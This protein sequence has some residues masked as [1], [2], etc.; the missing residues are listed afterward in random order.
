MMTDLPDQL[1]K[2]EQMARQAQLV[3]KEQKELQAM[4]EQQERQDQREMLVVQAQLVQQ[5]VM[6]ATEPTDLQVVLDRLVLKA[7]AQLAHRENKEN[8][9]Q[10]ELRD[11]LE[12]LVT[13]L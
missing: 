6:A 4:T 2:Q 1:V 12:H 8:L 3:Q 9:V 10:M 11:Q 5:E 13:L 7:Q